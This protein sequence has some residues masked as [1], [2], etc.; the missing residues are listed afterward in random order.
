MGSLKNPDKETTG[1]AGNFTGVQ[2]L[3]GE[4][5]HAGKCV[6]APS[7]TNSYRPPKRGINSPGAP[8]ADTA[9]RMKLEGHVE[10]TAPAANRVVTTSDEEALSTAG[11]A[12][13]RH[14]ETQGSDF[15]VGDEYVF[16]NTTPCWATANVHAGGQDPRTQ[17]GF[18]DLTQTT[19][20]VEQS[21]TT[22]SADRYNKHIEELAVCAIQAGAQENCEWRCLEAYQ[23]DPQTQSMSE[24]QKELRHHEEVLSG[25]LKLIEECRR[26]GTLTT[27][28]ADE[29][30][31]TYSLARLHV[32]HKAKTVRCLLPKSVA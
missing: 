3:S 10:E 26:V 23:W 2:S 20:C 31:Q 9:K 28:V 5:R 22:P 13:I 6:V 7:V 21:S 15:C 16:R 12:A 19:P 18:Q 25:C 30:A 17:K 32:R 14:L 1:D 4:H 29:L 24:A 8:L 11:K 27:A